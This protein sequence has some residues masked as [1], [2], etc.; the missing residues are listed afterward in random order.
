MEN[1]KETTWSQFQRSRNNKIVFWL[2][3]FVIFLGLVSWFIWTSREA[4]TNASIVIGVALLVQLVSYL[5][6]YFDKVKRLRR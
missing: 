1:K 3:N 6:V 2:F 4:R 5:A